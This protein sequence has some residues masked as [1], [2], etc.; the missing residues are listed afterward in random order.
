MTAE[1]TKPGSHVLRS[2]KIHEDDLK[3]ISH[4]HCA[5][6]GAS[7]GGSLVQKVTSGVFELEEKSARQFCELYFSNLDKDTKGILTAA[8]QSLFFTE[9]FSWTD[10]YIDLSYGE[11]NVDKP[12][13]GA[14][15]YMHADGGGEK[16]KVYISLASI[17]K[18]PSP[19]HYFLKD[20]FEGNQERIENALK[21][22]T[23]RDGLSRGLIE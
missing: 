16:R 5:T 2:Y 18:K 9:G 23:Y 13:T 12:I 20:Y 6:H 11:T 19:G 8:L 4:T 17:T 15:Y 3:W 22:I 1:S 10:K 21:Y 7:C 14:F